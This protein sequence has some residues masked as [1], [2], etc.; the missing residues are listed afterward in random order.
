VLGATTWYYEFDEA[1]NMRLKK[2]D[3]YSP[4]VTY[5][6]EYNSENR[7]T[8]YDGPNASNDA[9]YSY[10]AVGNRVQTVV[11]GV[12]K[13]FLFDGADCVADYDNSVSLLAYYVTPG[14]D[15][16]LLMR[17]DSADHYYAQDGL[18]SVRSIIDTSQA[19]THKYDYSAWGEQIAWET[20]TGAPENRYSFTGRE[21]DGES[22]SYS[23]RY[24]SLFPAIGCFEQRDPLAY[25]RPR[26]YLLDWGNPNMY[27]IGHGGLSSQPYGI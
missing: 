7:L 2:D 15:E 9:T 17:A 10:N 20:A 3:Q 8:A 13:K 18:G 26:G 21:W 16:N 25:I 11:G 22:Q 12:A 6:W 5:E 27:D 23:L 14:M 1:G 19:V 4:T 24:R